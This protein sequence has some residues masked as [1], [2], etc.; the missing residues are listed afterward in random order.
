[1]KLLQSKVTFS[2]VG[3]V[4]YFLNSATLHEQ[5]NTEAEAIYSKI[6]GNEDKIIQIIIEG[7]ASIEGSET[8]NLILSNKRTLSMKNF[9]IKK[10][11]DADR[12]VT[13]FNG[14]SDA[15]LRYSDDK[16]NSKPDPNDRYVKVYMLL[17]D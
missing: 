10:G 16:K 3:R 15:L 5:Q 11:I 13:S 6:K 14:N 4:N 17:N 1:M 9:L 2:A 7:N 8:Y 12:I